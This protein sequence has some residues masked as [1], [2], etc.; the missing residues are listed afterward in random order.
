M[1]DTIAWI[2]LGVAFTCAISIAVDESR[3]PQ[4][5]GDEDLHGGAEILSLGCRRRGHMARQLVFE[6]ALHPLGLGPRPGVRFVRCLCRL[7][8]SGITCRSRSAW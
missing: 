8:S 3:D 2:S 6:I 5:V 4:N 7:E 1:L